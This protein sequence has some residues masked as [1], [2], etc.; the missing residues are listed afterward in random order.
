MTGGHSSS[1]NSGDFI[2]DMPRRVVNTKTMQEGSGSPTL[3]DAGRPKL[4]LTSP[5]SSSSLAMDSYT[6]GIGRNKQHPVTHESMSS[7]HPSSSASSTPN[8]SDRDLLPSRLGK[9]SIAVLSNETSTLSRHRP[10]A[11]MSHID[12]SN[13]SPIL[14]VG[15]ESSPKSSAKTS[16]TTS[17]PSPANCDAPKLTQLTVRKPVGSAR[18]PKTSPI[19]HLR[20]KTMI[21]DMPGM[22]DSIAGQNRKS[23]SRPG[24]GPYSP[25]AED[26]QEKLVS[27]PSKLFGFQ[28]QQ[29][30]VKQKP[31]A[32]SNPT[33]SGEYIQDGEYKNQTQNSDLVNSSFR[34]LA[35]LS[36]QLDKLSFSSDDSS[37]TIASDS[38][39]PVVPFLETASSADKS[40]LNLKRT[41]SVTSDDSSSTVA[42]ESWN[43]VEEF[44]GNSSSDEELDPSSQGV[45][46]FDA[47]AHLGTPLKPTKKPDM[48]HEQMPWADVR[49]AYP[50]DYVNL[51]DHEDGIAVYDAA[52]LV[53]KAPETELE[54]T[55]V[56]LAPKYGIPSPSSDAAS[57]ADT[58]SPADA[59]SFTTAPDIIVQDDEEAKEIEPAAPTKVVHNSSDSVF[60]DS[61]NV[62]Q[63]F[64]HELPAQ[65]IRLI[66]EDAN[67]MFDYV[68]GSDGDDG[69]SPLD[70]SD[71]VRPAIPYTVTLNRNGDS[72]EEEFPIRGDPFFPTMMP[73]DFRRSHNPNNWAAN[74]DERNSSSG[75]LQRVSAHM[76][77]P[78]MHCDPRDRLDRNLQFPARDGASQ[79]IMS[80]PLLGDDDD[81][82]EKT[83]KCRSSLGRALDAVKGKSQGDGKLV[84]RRDEPGKWFLRRQAAR[85]DGFLERKNW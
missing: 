30:L 54:W 72:D 65:T 7:P 77:L 60:A 19:R 47:N 53:G 41:T 18:K 64:L 58:A 1:S 68:N 49:R 44:I 2:P 40:D 20:N 45:S 23:F 79:R 33:N 84:K 25:K 83:Y 9:E 50:L 10:G 75:F 26:C 80:T 17:K 71:V 31:I 39:N 34:N 16:S 82:P 74:Y 66:A 22:M 21:S 51:A 78:N 46:L 5:G 13:D 81:V 62:L 37:S 28:D 29:S 4:F 11:R 12:A 56:R 24:F 32:L 85:L 76:K 52:Y 6:R 38:W 3:E 67:S 63:N 42:D 61:E 8:S 73:P 70:E 27:K 35:E 43:P 15:L 69:S 59:T 55:D 57:L 48:N 36:S 14:A